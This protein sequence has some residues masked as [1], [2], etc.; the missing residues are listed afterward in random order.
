MRIILYN[1]HGHLIHYLFTD[2]LL[3]KGAI[4]PKRTFYFANTKYLW[5][6]NL[7]IK[8]WSNKK[9]VFSYLSLPYHH[10]WWILAIKQCLQEP[11]IIST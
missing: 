7:F 5:L 1:Q 10:S 11:P 9:N 4:H 8:L 6:Y 3:L 2:Y